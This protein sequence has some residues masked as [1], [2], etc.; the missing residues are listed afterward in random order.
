MQGCIQV[1][2][3]AGR[4]FARAAIDKTRPIKNLNFVQA[5]DLALKALRTQLSAAREGN[6]GLHVQLQQRQTEWKAASLQAA[7]V[8]SAESYLMWCFSLSWAAVR[9]ASMH[10][11]ITFCINA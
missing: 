8:S 1:S 3:V 2:T 11:F 10:E 6:A 5:Q 9:T 4:D 7:E